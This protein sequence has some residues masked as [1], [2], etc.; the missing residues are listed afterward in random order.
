MDSSPASPWTAL[1]AQL[2]DLV[3][4]SGVEVASLL[5]RGG[6]RITGS[7]VHGGL[8]RRFAVVTPAYALPIVFEARD[9]RERASWVVALAALHN[10]P[11]GLRRDAW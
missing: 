5:A 1:H 7:G 9:A 4:T 2:G 11:H 6:L 10:V 8:G 3:G